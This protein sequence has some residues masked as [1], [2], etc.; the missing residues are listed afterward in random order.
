MNQTVAVTGASGFVGREVV[1]QLRSR[2][3]R[4]IALSRDP[5]TA[6][7]PPDVETRRFD[8]NGGADP[9]AFEGA[10]AVI[11]LAGESVA[12]RWTPEK[13]R[14]IADS[15]IAG[16]RTVV[17]SI[18]AAARRPRALICASAIGY[19]GDRGDEPLPEDAE[20]G[21]DF[22]AGVCVGW[23]AAAQECEALGVRTVRMRTGVVL[24]NGGAL[25]Q[26][27]MPFQFGIGGPLGTGRQFVPWIHV[28]DL[29]AL[30]CFAVENPTLRGPVNAVTPDYATNS[31]LSQAIGAAI[32]RP[33]LLPAP[34]FALR[35]IL[36]GFADSLLAS[37]LVLPAAAFDA[38]FRWNHPHLEPAL[39][40]LLRRSPGRSHV[41]TFRATQIVPRSLDDVFAF[42]SDPRNLAAI[43]PPALGFATR[44]MP[45]RFGRGSIVEYDLRIHGFPVHWKTLIA[46]YE[47]KRRFVDVQLR[48]PYAL[49]EHVHEFAQVDGGIEV[50]DSIRYV[51]PG[52]PFGELAAPMVE[53]DIRNIFQFRRET[54][55]QTFK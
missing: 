29:A 43:T 3:A 18:K 25:A 33:S 41:R 12:G 49:W 21:T 2:G 19:Y 8:P 45:Q 5:E 40:A 11:H 14:G 48:G 10:D 38:G 4:V 52:A 36:G 53:R 50:S 46:E 42:F 54:I 22:L 15:R 26:M 39:A 30:Y 24:G 51:L 55:E 13:K 27:R 20:P 1:D 28:A 44:A 37:Q 9:A 32:G 47:P 31:R 17:E 7:F 16:T 35:T 34:S 23:E 6:G